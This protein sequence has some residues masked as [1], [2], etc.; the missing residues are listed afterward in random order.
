L[1]ITLSIPAADCL[2]YGIQPGVVEFL[3]PDSGYYF[4]CGL[5]AR[6]SALK[7][8]IPAKKRYKQIPVMAKKEKGCLKVL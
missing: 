8:K 4:G 1:K 5:L 7:F 3:M 2:N 6:I